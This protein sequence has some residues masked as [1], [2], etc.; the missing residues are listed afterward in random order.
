MTTYPGSLVSGFFGLDEKK[1]D[2]GPGSFEKNLE[3][4]PKDEEANKHRIKNSASGMGMNVVYA[5]VR[6][7]V[8]HFSMGL[9]LP[10]V[11]R[12]VGTKAEESNNAEGPSPIGNTRIYT[13]I[14]NGLNLLKGCA[15]CGSTIMP[16]KEVMKSMM[17]LTATE[18]NS[19]NKLYKP[20]DKVKTKMHL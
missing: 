14:F 11:L 17:K 20:G 16:P 7:G 12:D 4:I 3:L 8:T 13:R 6:P 10:T 15:G 19:L 18:L 9:A 2:A 1:N 5:C